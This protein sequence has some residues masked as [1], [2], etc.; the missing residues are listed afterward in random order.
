MR[1]IYDAV[2]NGLSTTEKHLIDL[3]SVA[4]V[5][6]SLTDLLPHVAAGFTVLWTG[7]RIWETDTVQ[8]WFGKTKNKE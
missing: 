6:G 1:T 4:T 8:G 3:A 7:I 5:V 2:H